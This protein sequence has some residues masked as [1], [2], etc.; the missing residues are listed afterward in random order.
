MAYASFSVA[1]S[2]RSDCES[3][4]EKRATEQPDCLSEAAMAQSEASI[5]I[6]RGIEGFTIKMA[7]LAMSLFIS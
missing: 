7:E 4:L 3:V 5:S 2:R 6:I 1:E